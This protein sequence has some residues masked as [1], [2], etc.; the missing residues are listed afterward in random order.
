MRSRALAVLE[1]NQQIFVSKAQMFRNL[2]SVHEDSMEWSRRVSAKRSWL[3]S[4]TCCAAGRQDLCSFCG[5]LI[6]RRPGSGIRLRCQSIRSSTAHRRHSKQRIHF[7]ATVTKSERVFA[8][9]AT[10]KIALVR[11]LSAVQELAIDC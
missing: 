11:S 2:A 10:S 3:L 1:R 8:L 7:S 4:Q 9:A 5:P 6:W